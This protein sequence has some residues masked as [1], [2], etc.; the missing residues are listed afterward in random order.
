MAISKCMQNYCGGIKNDELLKEGY[1]LLC[2]Y[3]N[4]FVPQLTCENPHDLMRIHEV[5]DI[6]TVSKMVIQACLQRK[7]TNT[8]LYFKRSDYSEINPDWNKKH[9]IISQENN[10]IKVREESLDYYG[11]LK[12]EY[13]KRN[14]DYIKEVCHE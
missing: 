8:T 13:E 11:N 10:E 7:C 14:Q 3:E 6:L 5:L 2:T 4:E 1:D 12:E 9:I